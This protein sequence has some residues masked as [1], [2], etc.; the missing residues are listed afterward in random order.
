MLDLDATVCSLVSFLVYFNIIDGEFVYDDIKAILKNDDITNTD[1]DVW[2]RM[3]KNDY[4]GNPLDYAG[5]HQSYR[6]ITVVSFKLDRIVFGM[7]S[8]NFHLTNILLHCITTYLFCKIAG[9]I[10]NFKRE[11]KIIAGLTFAVHP[12]HTEAVSGIVGRADILATLFCLSSVLCYNEFINDN[13][14]IK[15][16]HLQEKNITKKKKR[17]DYNIENQKTQEIELELKSINYKRTLNELKT[18]NN[19]NSRKQ[20]CGTDFYKLFKLEDIKRARTKYESLPKKSCEISNKYSK[21]KA[22]E[23]LCLNNKN[24]NKK[25]NYQKKENISQKKEGSEFSNNSYKSVQWLLFSFVFATLSLYSKEQGYCSLFICIALDIA[26]TSILK[27][28]S[29]IRVVVKKRRV[30]YIFFLAIAITLTRLNMPYFISVVNKNSYFVSGPPKFSRR[31]NPSAFCNDTTSRW[32]T[33]NYLIAQSVLMTVYSH[34]LC[35]DWGNL[36]LVIS[37]WDPRNLV[38]VLFYTCCVILALKVLK[39]VF[40]HDEVD[41]NSYVPVIFSTSVIFL[42]LLP[43]SNL[44][45][46]VGFVIA[47]RILY[48]P[49]VGSTL[50]MTFFLN[51]FKKKVKI[52]KATLWVL[53]FIIIAGMASKTWQRSYEWKN[54]LTLFKSGIVYNPGKSHA[55]LGNL[56]SNAGLYVQA[57]QS[58]KESLKYDEKNSDTYY[59]LGLLY[60]NMKKLNLSETCYKKAIQYRPKMAL[61]YLNLGVLF[62]QTRRLK[63]AVKSYKK[64]VDINNP[65]TRDLNSCNTAKISALYNIGRIMNQQSKFKDS[66][67]YYNEAIKLSNRNNY[68]QLLHKI[69]NM[70]GQSYSYLD[71][72]KAKNCY[73]KSLETNKTHLMTYLMYSKFLQ[74]NNKTKQAIKLLKKAEK[75]SP[76]SLISI[77]LG[78]LLIQ[79]G[80]K[81]N[82]L[83]KIEQA[84]I[85]NKKDYAIKLKV[86]ELYRKHKVLK[87][88]NVFNRTL[89]NL[90]SNV[91]SSS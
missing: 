65:T 29:I 16:K 75:I 56:Y 60:Y 68:H 78:N 48:L 38:T 11:M 43:A 57:E 88:S 13:I 73:D 18:T 39:L 36:P 34:N 58:Y 76:S 87:K 12:I 82:G 50:I 30:L 24:L 1:K 83:S 21:I 53:V 84:V 37:Y 77:E 15:T 67:Y 46:Y 40:Q 19:I 17:Y 91:N 31:D 8:Q 51:K 23:M 59:N 66:I 6:P 90:S 10:C 35:F 85:H 2:L 25:L 33:F 80:D 4:W 64:V 69:Y 42:S 55:C 3:W 49:S 72:K 63:E 47:E 5:S 71:F 86:A 89:F 45:F 54:E 28:E 20:N 79:S 14:I 9:N 26:K 27:L 44:F 70:M 7:R 52:C 41:K 74:D 32:L 62:G 81:N 22:F 61:S